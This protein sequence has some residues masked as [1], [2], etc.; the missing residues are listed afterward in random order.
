MHYHCPGLS[1]SAARAV[2]LTLAAA[3]HAV[4][5]GVARI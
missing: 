5:L 3:L 4:F 2:F 1:R